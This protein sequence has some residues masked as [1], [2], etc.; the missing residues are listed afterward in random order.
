[1]SKASRN[2]LAQIQVIKQLMEDK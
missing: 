1:M 2:S